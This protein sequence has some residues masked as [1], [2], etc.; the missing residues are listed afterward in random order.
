[1]NRFR[2]FLDS[3]EEIENKLEEDEYLSDLFESIFNFLDEVDIDNLEPHQQEMF[4]EILEM[5]Q[6]DDELDEEDELDE[7]RYKKVVRGGKRK[8][9]RSCG[10]G[11]KSQGGKCVKISQ[12]EKR[13]RSKAAKKAA[14]KRKGKKSQTERKRKRSMKKR[15]NV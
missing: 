10:K 6:G 15:G 3:E 14:K 2:E 11:Y 5:T 8:R 4:E 12:K 7:A 1:M 9:K 13:V